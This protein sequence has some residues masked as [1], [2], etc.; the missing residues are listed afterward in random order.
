MAAAAVAA[1]DDQPW[2]SEV[3]YLLNELF[4]SPLSFSPVGVSLF[5]R[6]NLFNAV[7]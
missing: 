1:I 3:F 6:A 2:K 5:E 7:Q 4:L